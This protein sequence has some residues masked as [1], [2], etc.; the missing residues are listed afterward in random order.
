MSGP[1]PTCPSCGAPTAA[2]GF[3]PCPACLMRAA[4]RER[5]GLESSSERSV[6]RLGAYRLVAELESGGMG[7]VYLG[8][9]DRPDRPVIV[10]VPRTNLTGEHGATVFAREVESLAALEHPGVARVYG[11]ETFPDGRPCLVMEY[12]DGLPITRHAARHAMTLTDRLELLLEVCEAVAHAHQR[13]VIHHDLKPDNILIAV[14]DGRPVPKLIDFGLSRAF[15]LPHG[16]GADLE[17]AGTPGSMSPEQTLPGSPT[18]ARSDVYGLGAVLYELVSESPPFPPALF[19]GRNTE[20]IFTIIRETDPPPASSHPGPFQ[21]AL[22][23]DLDAIAR[24]ALAR[25][26]RNRYASVTEMG[27]DIRRHLRHEPVQAVA[28]GPFYRAGKFLR[29]HR[30]AVVAA[31]AVLA[32]LTAVAILFALF[33]TPAG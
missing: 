3:G 25:K 26:K 33:K 31:G 4:L 5:D 28:G 9:Q 1:A 10:K 11:T 2:W 6:Q 15:G 17:V 23:G 13:G 21:Q 22:R 12:V 7:A 20:E 18:D 14:P 32:T 19:A 16:A 29:R 24:M 27:E 30:S 8:R